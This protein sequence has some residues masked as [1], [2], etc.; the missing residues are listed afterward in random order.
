M[1]TSRQQQSPTLPAKPIVALDS[2]DQHKRRGSPSSS[3]TLTSSKKTTTPQGA[4]PLLSQ[5]FGG[6]SSSSSA[7]KKPVRVRVGAE[8]EILKRNRRNVDH[9][10][11]RI[12]ALMGREVSLNEQGMAFFS[13]KSKFVVVVEV[14]EDNNTMMYLYTMVCRAEENHPHQMAV[15]KR[16][17]E[18]NYMQQGTAGATLGLDGEEVNYC[19]SCKISGLTFADLKATMESFLLTAVEINEE[20]DAIKE[21]GSPAVAAAAAATTPRG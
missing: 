11:R 19:Y 7:S 16:A 12:G 6:V 14:P 3:P 9:Y 21:L 15:V 18:L 2:K 13:Y 8:E 20:L 1:K 4:R 17:M 5:L 10:V